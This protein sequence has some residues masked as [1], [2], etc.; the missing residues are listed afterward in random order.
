MFL[1]KDGFPEPIGFTDAD[2]NKETVRLFSDVFCLHYLHV[3]T[4][5]G[6]LGHITSLSASV[7]KDLRSFY[8]SCDN[9]AKKMYHQT[10]EL[11]LEK[12][13]FQRDP[14][15]YPE[16][17]PEFVTGQQFLDGFFGENPR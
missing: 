14:Y 4:L 17:A 13:H 15:F 9:E 11:L 6:L 10:I 3:M 7:R 2:L 5:H 16:S 8:D 1:E 12:D